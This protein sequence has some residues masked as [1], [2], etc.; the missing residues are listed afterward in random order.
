MASPRACGHNAAMQV[1]GWNAIETGAGP[2]WWREYGFTKGAWATML[3]FRGTDGLVVLSPGNGVESRA[4]DALAELGDVRALVATNAYH[5]LGQ[6]EWRKRFPNAES[7]APPGALPRLA[8]KAASVPFRSLAELALPAGVR[9]EDAPGFSIG[10]TIVRFDSPEGVVWYSGDLLTNIVRMP[11][12]P[13]SWLMKLTGSAPG[14]RLFKLG[15]WL[16]VKDK[17][18]VREWALE[19]LAKEPP[20]AIVPAHGPAIDGGDL[21]E[22]ALAELRRL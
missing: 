2:M 13:A 9:W 15:T 22:R 16:F 17:K 6:P 8:K 7:Y 20:I 10:E 14:F 19:R 1:E 18:A 5:H 4:L 21:A 11:G 3:A 12:P